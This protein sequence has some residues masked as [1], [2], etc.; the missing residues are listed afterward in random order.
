[1]EGEIEN[2]K[3]EKEE[4]EM[5]IK[6]IEGKNIE[7][8]EDDLIKNRIKELKEKIN[9]KESKDLSKGNVLRRVD[10]EIDLKIDQILLCWLNRGIVKQGPDVTKLIAKHKIMW[11]ELENYKF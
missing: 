9:K 10:N 7:N 3:Q 6:K 5:K 11:G 8:I 2:L 4:I 1:M